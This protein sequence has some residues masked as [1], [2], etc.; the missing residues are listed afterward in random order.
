[1]NSN[2]DRCTKYVHLLGIAS[3]SNTKSHRIDSGANLAITV[4]SD[5]FLLLSIIITFLFLTIR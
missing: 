2:A 1:M 5:S 3:D 4:D